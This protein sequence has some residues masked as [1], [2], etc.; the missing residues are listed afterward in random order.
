[1][2]QRRLCRFQAGESTSIISKSKKKTTHFLRLVQKGVRHVLRGMHTSPAPLY[3]TDC[4]SVVKGTCLNMLEVHHRHRASFQKYTLPHI[5]L[6]ADP[7][8][9]RLVDE[10]LIPPVVDKKENMSNVNTA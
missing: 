4:C 2:N 7:G 5:V 6:A 9:E 8:K 3:Q 10:P 1:M